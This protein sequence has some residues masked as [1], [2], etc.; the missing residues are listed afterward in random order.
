MSEM[1]TDHVRGSDEIISADRLLRE[2]GQLLIDNEDVLSELLKL[3]LKYKISE[4]DLYNK[5]EEYMMKRAVYSKD[6]Q[7]EQAPITLELIQNLDKELA[8]SKASHHSIYNEKVTRAKL[9]ISKYKEGVGFTFSNS[10]L[11]VYI[12]TLIQGTSPDS[13]SYEEF[14]V[15]KEDSENVI[16]SFNTHLPIVYYKMNEFKLVH[17]N[18]KYFE[19]FKNMRYMDIDMDKVSEY[20]SSRIEYMDL[21]FSQRRSLPNLNAGEIYMVG[22]LSYDTTTHEHPPNLYSFS[23][24]VP[25][26]ITGPQTMNLDLSSLASCGQRHSLFP[27]QMVALTGNSLGSV[28]S[29]EVLV[30]RIFYPPYYI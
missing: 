22:K 17:L 16:V 24:D 6:I 5:F 11:P 29:N 21:L 23:F 20:I 2:F 4:S 9:G 30:T 1:E 14:N 19:D 10:A 27:G 25:N 7:P 18:N 28:E 13:N 26:R 15:T 12:K 8:A 3:G